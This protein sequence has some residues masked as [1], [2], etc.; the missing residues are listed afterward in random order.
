MSHVTPVPKQVWT[1][2][3]RGRRPISLLWNFP[4]RKH[5]VGSGQPSTLGDAGQGFTQAGV[6]HVSG[7]WTNVHPPHSL[8][9]GS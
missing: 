1:H 9:C 2:Q 6:L 4:W 3:H 5:R 7:A 8:I